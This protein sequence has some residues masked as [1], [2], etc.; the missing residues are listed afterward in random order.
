MLL[1]LIALSTVNFFNIEL[2]FN[3]GIAFGLF[4]NFKYMALI[5]SGLA[6]TVILFLVF[7][8]FKNFKINI[9]L[10]SAAG[11]AAAN[12]AER[13]YLGCV[14]DY[15]NILYSFNLADIEIILGLT[16]AMGLY[17]LEREK[18]I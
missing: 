18:E 10:A 12:F 6:L 8:K 16:L 17:L 2:K 4:N 9:A 1:E 13:L 7:Y 15:I 11:G 14:I 5:L 3:Y